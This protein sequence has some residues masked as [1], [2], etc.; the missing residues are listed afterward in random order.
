MHAKSIDAPGGAMSW[1][2]KFMVGA[3]ALFIAGC[4][5]FFSVKGL[6]LL[7]IG[8][9]TAVMV[10]AASLELGKLIAGPLSW[11][12]PYEHCRRDVSPATI[13]CG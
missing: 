2:F 11:K 12:T 4:S 1:S 7:F 8:S 13:C 6:G 5:A 3:A 10:M 9:A